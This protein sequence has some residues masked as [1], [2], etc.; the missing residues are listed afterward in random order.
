MLYAF[1]PLAYASKLKNSPETLPL[2]RVQSLVKSDLP[3]LTSYAE[4]VVGGEHHGFVSEIRPYGCFVNF[5]NHVRWPA[6]NGVEAESWLSLPRLLTLL[7]ATQVGGLVPR[8]EI[9]SSA[10]LMQV[11]DMVRVGQ[12]HHHADYAAFFSSPCQLSIVLAR[13][14][15]LTCKG[16]SLPRVGGRCRGAPPAPYYA[17]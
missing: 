14:R 11:K 16:G 7:A 5:Y 15:C 13:R 3:M 9:S 4:A 6:C 2:T 17:P 12:V 8:E 1:C 10:A